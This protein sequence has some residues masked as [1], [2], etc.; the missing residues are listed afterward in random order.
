MLTSVGYDFRKNWLK[1]MY[2]GSGSPLVVVIT[3]CIFVTKSSRSIFS[4]AAKSAIAV[5][6][7][8]T[9]LDAWTPK[10]LGLES[11]TPG[12]LDAWTSAWADVA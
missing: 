9:L 7:G 12:L 10:T 8:I 4:I 1:L 11:L 3:S 6:F 5:S 2:L